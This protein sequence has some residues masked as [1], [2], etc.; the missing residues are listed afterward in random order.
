MKAC[1]WVALLSLFAVAYGATLTTQVTARRPV[2]SKEAEA[3]VIEK[4]G[5]TLETVG[6]LLQ[7]ENVALTEEVQEDLI[8]ALRVASN[9]GEVLSE[10]GSEYILPIIIRGVAQGVIAHVVHKKLNKG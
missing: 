1:L 2:L 9:N 8:K 3:E 4:T 7:G 5:K 6:R 10:D